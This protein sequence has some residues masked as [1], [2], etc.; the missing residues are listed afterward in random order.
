VA[1]KAMITKVQ[2]LV[3]GSDLAEIRLG[4]RD[5][6][7]EDRVFTQWRKKSIYGYCEFRNHQPPPTAQYIS[8]DLR[9]P[10]SDWSAI[11]GARVPRGAVGSRGN[12]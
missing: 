4:L 10:S 11:I 9:I 12:R 2:P 8:I 5:S 7:D 6:P 3:E 1:R